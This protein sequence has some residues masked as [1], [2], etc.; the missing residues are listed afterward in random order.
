MSGS[1]VLIAIFIAIVAAGS[2]ARSQED[3]GPDAGPLRIGVDAGISS[4]A[5]DGPIVMGRAPFLAASGAAPRFDVTAD[6]RLGSAGS[7]W[8]AEIAVGFTRESMSG[9]YNSREMIDLAVLS[10]SENIMVDVD[11]RNTGTMITDLLA[12]APSVR[13]DVVDW[14][15]AGLGADVGVRIGESTTQFQKTLLSRALDVP[16][17]GVTNV[18]FPTEESSDGVTKT[19]PARARTN[20]PVLT[21]GAM[22]YVGAE[23]GIGSGITLGPR[24]GYTI[25][26]GPYGH[27]PDF[28]IKR[29]WA[30]AALRYQL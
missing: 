19:F 27:D 26:L 18:S 1:N 10:G 7:R 15:Y 22:M 4:I 25:G 28:A 3:S 14:L 6:L 21:L 2:T 29:F 5:A 30:A 8:R 17:L 16:G 20:A 24:V 9:S 23:I 12:I 13:Y 11:F